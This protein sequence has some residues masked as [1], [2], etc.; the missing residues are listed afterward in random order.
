MSS[1]SQAIK[2]SRALVR[3]GLRFERLNREEKARFG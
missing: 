3:V 1:E 2:T